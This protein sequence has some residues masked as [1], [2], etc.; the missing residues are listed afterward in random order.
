MLHI[1]PR[2]I[3]FNSHDGRSFDIGAISR[4][5]N[6][7]NIEKCCR[8]H[9]TITFNYYSTTTTSTNRGEIDIFGWNPRRH[10]VRYSVCLWSVAT[11]VYELWR[12]TCLLAQHDLSSPY[13]TIAS[14]R[15]KQLRKQGLAQHQM[16]RSVE[17]GQRILSESR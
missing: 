13:I 4:Y 11:V 1:A 8:H 7:I 14:T 5:D 17:G 16:G 6:E 10:H 9:A 3:R 12:A 15:E 2:C